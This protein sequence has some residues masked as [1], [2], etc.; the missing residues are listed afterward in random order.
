MGYGIST[1]AVLS[2]GLKGHPWDPTQIRYGRFLGMASHRKSV[3][4]V[5]SAYH[6]G[7]S[8]KEA[9]RRQ[10]AESSSG[11]SQVVEKW[12]HI[13]QLQVPGKLSMFLWRLVHNTLPTRMNIKR[14]RIDLDTR[15]R[16]DEH[17]GHL[18]LKTKKVKAVW[19]EQGL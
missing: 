5:K 12:K 18:S 11:R 8:V 15:C 16:L 9:E 6:L 3:F 10:N 19:R 14:K 1:R 13:W 4:S 7:V 17:S 2:R